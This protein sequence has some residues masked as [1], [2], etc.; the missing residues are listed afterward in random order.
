MLPDSTDSTAYGL[1][2]NNRSF[3]V[4]PRTEFDYSEVE[5]ALVDIAALTRTCPRAWA[6]IDATGGS[7]VL[8]SHDSVWG[9]DDTVKPTVADLGPGAYSITWPATV[10]D[11]NPTVARRVTRNVSFKACWAQV[12]SDGQSAMAEISASNV[13]YVSTYDGGGQSDTIFTVF[14][15]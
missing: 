14:V 1:P 12:N 9:N 2:K 3:V 13:V 7:P 11:L 15:L 10:A 8:V 4:D 5:A 6:R